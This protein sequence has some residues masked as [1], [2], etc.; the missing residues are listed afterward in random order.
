MRDARRIELNRLLQAIDLPAAPALDRA[1]IKPADPDQN[2]DGADKLLGGKRASAAL[3][4]RSA[5]G[6]RFFRLIAIL[7]TPID[8]GFGPPVST[9]R[10]G[11]PMMEIAVSR[12]KPQR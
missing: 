11:S 5:R 7:G 1:G 3:A 9:G 2:I 6:T 8:A 10:I 12:I 4:T